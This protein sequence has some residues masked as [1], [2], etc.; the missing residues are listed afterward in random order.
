MIDENLKSLTSKIDSAVTDKEGECLY[1]L[2][3]N[4][5]GKGVIVE[6]GSWKGKSTILLAKGS[7]AGNKL[8]V[9]AIDPHTGSAEHREM[10]GEVWTFDEFKKN[11]ETARVDH[12]IV[13]ILKT[14]IEAAKDFR[15][16]VE[17]IFV[18]G[19]HEYDLVK[20]DF[21]LWF[22]KVI[23]GGVMVFHDTT[24]RAGPKRVVE[25]LVYKSRNFR[26]VTFIDDSIT[27]A[28]KTKRVSLKDRLKN[29][30]VLFLKRAYEVGAKL[31]LPMTIR[32][33]GKKIVT[34]AQ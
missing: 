3:K 29:R 4:C 28:E 17:L 33:I 5:Q 24:W 19:S 18:D 11:I 15:D 1:R 32:A 14:S 30:Y 10:Y 26:N 9:Y 2:A 27:Y 34:L 23:E 20:L 8:K 6:I 31:S 13:P 16:P 25:E 22:P 7:E 21:D 12:L